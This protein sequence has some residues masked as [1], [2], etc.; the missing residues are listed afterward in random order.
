MSATQKTSYVDV[1]NAIL[2]RIHDTVWAPGSLM[3]GEVALSEEFGCA[4]ATVNRAL[5]ELASDGVIERKRKAGTRIKSSPTRQGEGR[6]VYAN[7]DVY[8]GNFE[9]DQ[10]HIYIRLHCS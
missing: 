10:R 3:P 7:G 1:K 6:V 2:K 9:K 8:D 4:R 5:R